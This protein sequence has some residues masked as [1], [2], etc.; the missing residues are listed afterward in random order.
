MDKLE[1][2]LIVLGSA[3]GIAQLDTILGII[4]MSLQII[5]VLY[6]LGVKVATKIKDGKYNDLEDDIKDAKDDL[7]KIKDNLDKEE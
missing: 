4:I 7:D 1:N 3:I 5:L 6:K 2:T